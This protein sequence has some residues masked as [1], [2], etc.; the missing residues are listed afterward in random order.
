M[1]NRLKRKLGNDN[2]NVRINV[3][4][5]IQ[6]CLYE[7]NSLELAINN[8]KYIINNEINNL[9]DDLKSKIYCYFSIW[10]INKMGSD[11]FY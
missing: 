10:N 2:K 11:I 1:L 8:L 7:N 6:K 3:E 9:N 5:N 4:L